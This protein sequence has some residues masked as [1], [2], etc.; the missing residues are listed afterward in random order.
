MAGMFVGAGLSD[1]NYDAL[2]IGWSTIDDDE[3]E[4]GIR[5][6]TGVTLDA[7]ARYC[8]GTAGKG[9]LT[10]TYEWTITDGRQ[11][12]SCSDDASLSALSID[13]GSLNET[14]DSATTSYTATFSSAIPLTV[15]ATASDVANATVTI[16]GT[17]TDDTPLTVTDTTVSGF[18]AGENI[19][20]ITVTA[21]DGTMRPYMITVTVNSEL[22]LTNPG[23][24]NFTRGQMIS[25]ALPAA[26][27]G[28]GSYT[29]TLTGGVV[30][31]LGLS[32]N[33]STR[34]LSG[35]FDNLGT[36]GST[37]RG[38][39]RH[40]HSRRQRQSHFSGEYL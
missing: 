10:G 12:A 36:F 30:S 7:D 20:T 19:I 37:H 26:V 27:G 32:F 11:I 38:L 8:A 21:Q 9:I 23:P 14:F 5:L 16:V 40:G 34:V 2:L 25:V 29:Y 17:D 28:N 13:P 6:Q 18:T 24:Q 35:M 1:G 31:G 39:H 15:A 3:E 22:T 33:A 4:D